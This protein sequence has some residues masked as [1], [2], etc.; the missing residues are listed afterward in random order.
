MVDKAWQPTAEVHKL[1]KLT[2]EQKESGPLLEGEA[3]IS[4]V[5]ET[6]EIL[7]VRQGDGHLTI[8]LRFGRLWEGPEGAKVRRLGMEGAVRWPLATISALYVS[9]QTRTGVAKL[10][11]QAFWKTTKVNRIGVWHEMEGWIQKLLSRYGY[12]HSAVHK[13]F[14]VHHW[15][16]NRKN[17]DVVALLVERLLQEQ[18]QHQGQRVMRGA[19]NDRITK[20]GIRLVFRVWF[21]RNDPASLLSQLDDWI[22]GLLPHGDHIRIDVDAAMV[23]K[24]LQS[25]NIGLALP[26]LL[27]NVYLL[28]EHWQLC[29]AFIAPQFIPPVRM[30]LNE[31][32]SERVQPKARR[33][34]WADPDLV[35]DFG[36]LC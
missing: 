29:D 13:A 3:S 12:W 6:Q 20:D 18:D 11:H 24:E 8:E 22:E 30:G 5:R 25:K 14:G 36:D 7:Q 17:L 4:R 26:H 28:V 15:T 23:P 33:L 27:F 16:C 32:S 9:F 31:V 19:G 21:I 10:K 34:L 35:D 2:I 1:D